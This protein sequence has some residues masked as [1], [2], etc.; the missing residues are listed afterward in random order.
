[1]DTKPKTKRTR[2]ETYHNGVVL[3]EKRSLPMQTSKRVRATN[4]NT[5]Y[6][7]ILLEVLRN[8]LYNK[9]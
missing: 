6:Q 9:Q 7:K 1:M 2:I 8:S 3:V 5:K 4:N